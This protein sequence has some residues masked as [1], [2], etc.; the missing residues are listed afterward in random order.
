MAHNDL[1]AQIATR[2]LDVGTYGDLPGTKSLFKLKYDIGGIH[3]ALALI[4]IGTECEYSSHVNANMFGMGENFITPQLNE[5]LYS[6]DS[7]GKKGCTRSNPCNKIIK[8][9]VCET[10]DD[11]VDPLCEQ[12]S[13]SM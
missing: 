3:E 2:V 5:P 8:D 13:T 7:T 9:G 12:I 6:A 1:R 10:T 4:T 11:N